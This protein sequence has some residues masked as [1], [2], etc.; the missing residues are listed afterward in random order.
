MIN[1]TKEKAM[2]YKALY[3]K[4]QQAKCQIL[5]EIQQTVTKKIQW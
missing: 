3:P 1:T 4:D 5:V 2:K